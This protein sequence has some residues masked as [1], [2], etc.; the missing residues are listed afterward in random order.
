MTEASNLL[1]IEGTLRTKMGKN[2]C[3]KLRKA[4]QK[5]PANLL[6]QGDKSS[7]ELDS[8]LL[9]KAW[10]AEKKF[11]LK[12]GNETKAVLI[13]ELQISPVSRIPLHVDLQ[14]I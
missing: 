7:I 10:K 6:G 11:N 12:Y 2:Y 5:I 14:Y 1:R 3:R 4:G 9:S 8:K 13:K